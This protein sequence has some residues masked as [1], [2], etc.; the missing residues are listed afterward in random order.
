MDQPTF[1]DLEYQG[2]RRKTRRELLLEWMGDLIQWQWW[3]T[4]SLR[5]TPRPAGAATATLCR[6]CCES[7]ASCS[8]TT[9]SA[10][11]GQA[12]RSRRGGPALRGRIGQ[13][14]YGAE[15]VGG[16]ARRD[17]DCQL[18]SSLG[19]SRPGARPLGGNQCPPGLPRAEVAR[20]K[21]RGRHHH[22]GADIDQEPCRGTGPGDAS[23]QEGEPV[24]FRDEGAGEGQEPAVDPD[25][26]WSIRS[27]G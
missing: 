10:S 17:H 3:R 9:P 1:A 4:A 15:V 8:S 7:T 5:S 13:M 14:V 25:R 19:K 21:Y 2:K 27:C 24:A 20:G 11:S 16:P 22:R 6:S 26:G 12:Q 18:P 23:D